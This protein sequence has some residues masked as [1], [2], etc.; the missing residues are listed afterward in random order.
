MLKALRSP[1]GATNSLETFGWTE[2]RDNF[3]IYMWFKQYITIIKIGQAWIFCTH[4]ILKKMEQENVSGFFFIYQKSCSSSTLQWQIIEKK[5]N[6]KVKSL[7]DETCTE[8][9]FNWANLP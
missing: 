3:N 4:Q 5:L 9:Q 6:S 1:Y 8:W 7:K 2:C